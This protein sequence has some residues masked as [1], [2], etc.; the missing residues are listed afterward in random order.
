VTRSAGLQFANSL[1]IGV[2]GKSFG[3]PQMLCFGGTWLLQLVGTPLAKEICRVELRGWFKATK[4]K[5]MSTL[6]AKGNWNITKGK[7][8]QMLARLADDDLQFIEGKE[9]EL[10]GRIQKRTGQFRKKSDAAVKCFRS[11]N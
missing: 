10:I 5:N 7:M 1:A 9:D 3:E 2:F 6:I 11:H 4:H 8:K